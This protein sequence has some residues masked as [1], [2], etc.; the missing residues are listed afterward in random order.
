MAKDPAVLFYHHDFLIGTE[1]MLDEDVGKYIRL[2]CHQADRG[3]LTKKQVLSI[4]KADAI[5]DGIKDKLLIDKNG[6]YYNNRMDIE[7]KKRVKFTE[8]RRNNALSTKVY[9]EHMLKHMVNR[10]RDVN[11]DNKI[12]KKLRSWRKPL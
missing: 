2:L 5:P 7:K 6:D 10:N 8:S 12:E 11:K 4:C 3:H 9:A 1:F